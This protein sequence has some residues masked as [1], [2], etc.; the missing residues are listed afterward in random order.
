MKHPKK[1][2]VDI[3]AHAEAEYPKE[4][5]GLIVVKGRRKRYIPCKNL[6]EENQM[7][8]MDPKDYADAED[9]GDILTV[10]HS[11]CNQNPEPSQADRVGCEKSGLPWL[12]VSWPTQQV[13]ELKPTGYEAPF[14][15]REFVHGVVDCYTLF[16]DYYRVK[17]GI[18]IPDFHRE[19]QWWEKGQDL[20]MDNF[21]EA[22][23][24]QVEVL[25]EHTGILMNIASTVPNHIAVYISEQKILHHVQGRLSTRDV[26]GG[27]WK[28][29]AR[30]FLRHESLC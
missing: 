14:I 19:D 3:F 25:T 17:L 22:G 24:I 16:R 29:H 6:S 12:I 26:W 13:H 18:E 10:V 8:S 21:K 9:S 27:Y 20:Y 28:K 15:G 1:I 7:F 11:H 23:F 5:C 4:A 30:L 2:M